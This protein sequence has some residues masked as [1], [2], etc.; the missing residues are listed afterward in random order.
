MKNLETLAGIVTA[1]VYL[2]EYCGT[3]PRRFL[4]KPKWKFSFEALYGELALNPQPLPPF[5][6]ATLVGRGLVELMNRTR[7]A[8]TFADD[9]RK[10]V[11]QENAASSLIALTGD[12]GTETIGEILRRLLQKLD[13]HF[14]PIPDPDP[15]PWWSKKFT[16]ADQFLINSIVHTASQNF[17]GLICEQVG[18]F[19]AK[20]LERNFKGL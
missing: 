15:A 12:C 9:A 18:A 2:D 10:K 4:P 8:A 3:I 5:A 1:S 13:R 7:E 11:I 20:N 17:E 16:N 14:P 6:F 19:A